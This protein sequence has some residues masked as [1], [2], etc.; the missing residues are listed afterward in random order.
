MIVCAIYLLCRSSYIK[1]SMRT[2]FISFSNM[3]VQLLF[4]LFLTIEPSQITLEI[5]SARKCHTVNR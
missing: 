4:K 3:L 1:T 2:D 5:F